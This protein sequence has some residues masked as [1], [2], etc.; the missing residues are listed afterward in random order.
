M[1]NWCSRFQLGA[2][3][4]CV[5]PSRP[6]IY[7]IRALEVHSQQWAASGRE[8]QIGF[9]VVAAAAASNCSLR[10]YYKCSSRH[11][12]KKKTDER[13]RSWPKWASFGQFSCSLDAASTKIVG[14]REA[15]RLSLC[16]S[17]QVSRHQPTAAARKWPFDT[18]V[19]V[20]R[21]IIWLKTHTQRAHT[22]LL[23]LVV[24]T[25]TTL[26]DIWCCH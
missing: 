25:W 2:L 13:R 26:G 1:R 4:V 19:R 15:R 22:Q 16:L 8:N 24:Y 17:V 9:V 14:R 12:K 10:A 20:S 21:W 18:W 7:S 23:Q 3:C 11:K 5:Q 6:L